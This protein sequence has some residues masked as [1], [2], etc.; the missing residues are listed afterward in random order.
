MKRFTIAAA[1]VAMFATAAAAQVTP[2]AGYTPP[3]DTP[4]VN[5]GATIF[6]DYTYKD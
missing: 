6:G 3:D 1:M 2:A 5:V 4:K